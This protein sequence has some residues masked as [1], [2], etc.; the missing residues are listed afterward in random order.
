MIIGHVGPLWSLLGTHGGSKWP[1]PHFEIAE[2][3]NL[4]YVIYE[5]HLISLLYVG[6]SDSLSFCVTSSFFLQAKAV[7]IS[8]IF[9]ISPSTN[10]SVSSRIQP[11]PY[12]RPTSSSRTTQ[13]DEGTKFK[14]T[15]T[16]H[17]YFQ[18][19]CNLYTYKLS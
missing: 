3:P 14:Q 2:T 4:Y 11:C 12:Y 10:P 19:S 13:G 1:H 7:I 9:R 17:L 6:L 16:M 8:A 15:N 5:Q 18:H